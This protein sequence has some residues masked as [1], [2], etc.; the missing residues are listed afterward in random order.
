MPDDGFWVGTATAP[1]TYRLV[2]L[3]GSG[4]E[5]DV[6]KAE[7][8]LSRSGCTTVAVKIMRSDGQDAD[9]ARRWVQ[10]GHLLRSLSHPGLVRV[11]EV[12]TGPPM[13]RRGEVDLASTAAY[14]VM[15]YIEGPTLR[16]W[17]DENP[18]ATASER[19]GML[20][21]V[22]AALDVMHAGAGTRVP[23][24]H[25]D[26]KPSNIVVHGD[27]AGTVLVDLGLVRLTDALGERGHSTP[28]AAPE[29]RAPGALATPESDRYAFAVTTAQV[30]T[31]QRPPTGADGWTDVSALRSLLRAS[32][33]TRRRP[34]L[35]RQVMEAITAPLDGRPRHLQ[36]WLDSAADALS[37]VTDVGPGAPPRMDVAAD[38][39]SRIDTDTGAFAATTPSARPRGRMALVLGA[40]A[41]VLAVGTGIA[42]LA[43]RPATDAQADPPGVATSLPPTPAS[44]AG[45][46][47][48]PTTPPGTERTGE[49]TDLDPKEGYDFD[50]ADR[51]GPEDRPGLD[52]SGQSTQFAFDSLA[53]KEG[54]PLKDTNDGGRLKRLPPR[55][56]PY[57]RQDCDPFV[58]GWTKNV[59]GVPVGG[60]VCVITSDGN[61]AILTVTKAWTGPGPQDR[62][63]GFTYRVWYA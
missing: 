10:F 49:V 7:L 12:F 63:I 57:T 23:V 51:G 55:A 14:V 46:T 54:G 59:P 1:D 17:C 50:F 39:P 25:G 33:V 15:D 20:R 30:L 60:S 47:V 37:Q 61:I 27:G 5:G 18:D 62:L 44:A 41:L 9:A 16:D 53:T 40:V 4:G 13:H 56:A 21:T 22:A 3:L 6:W 31:G 38:L 35:V 28:Y 42:A 34:V 24:A 52:I 8:P 32:P 26:V 48:A 43:M 36:R 11:T 58:P 45:P 2:A 19:L 29:L